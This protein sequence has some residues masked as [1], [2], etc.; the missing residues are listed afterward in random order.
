MLTIHQGAI[1]SGDG[2]YDIFEHLKLSGEPLIPQLKPDFPLGKPDPPKNAIEVEEAVLWMKKYRVKYQNYWLSTSNQTSTGRPFDAVLLPVI[3]SAAVIPGKLYHYSYITAANVIDH[4]T[5]VIPVTRA[6]QSIDKFDPDYVPAG[7][8][9]KKHW[10]SCSFCSPS[11][12][13][14]FLESTD[15]KIKM[16]PRF[17]TA[18]QPRSRFLVAGC[19]R[20]S[21][22]PLARSSPMLCK[23]IRVRLCHLMKEALWSRYQTRSRS[24]MCVRA[25]HHSY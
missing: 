11:H 25:Q 10:E 15:L 5:L 3:P 20:K 19:K 7:D 2:N 8:L 13:L 14:F 6:N 12:P 4:A 23:N 1:A 18:P 17:T 9:D 21:S 24:Y 22:W 16:T